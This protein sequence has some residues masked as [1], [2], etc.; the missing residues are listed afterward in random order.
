[1]LEATSCLD[2]TKDVS[3]IALDETTINCGQGVNSIFSVEENVAFEI[4]TLDSSFIT[5]DGG[6]SATAEIK[7]TE[8]LIKAEKDNSSVTLENCIFQ[9]V[10][11]NDYEKGSILYASGSSKINMKNCTIQQNIGVPIVLENTNH[12][13]FD[14]C[15]FKNNEAKNSSVYASAIYVN[16]STLND[17]YEPAPTSSKVILNDCTF[18]DNIFIT[19]SGT[20][21]TT[22]LF[23]DVGINIASSVEISNCSFQTNEENNFNLYIYHCPSLTFDGT[24]T[25]PY[26]FFDNTVS[27]NVEIVLNDAVY[28]EEKTNIKVVYTNVYD[29]TFSSDVALFKEGCNNVNSYFNL[30]NEGYEFDSN[31]SIV[32]SE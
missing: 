1:M 8:S 17:S 3:I 16:D 14:S 25:L 21:F 7:K 13:E 31:G 27:G 15:T 6:N 5:F 24:T 19:P 2:I 20:G 4:K 22:E 28:F 9:N 32:N 29:A 26:L 18:S 23:S 11:C 10:N 30:T 12:S